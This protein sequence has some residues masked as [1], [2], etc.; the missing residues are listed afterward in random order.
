[1]S[2][3]SFTFEDLPAGPSGEFTL[4][5][6]ISAKHRVHVKH[7]LKYME[8]KREQYPHILTS[9]DIV[10]TG[11]SFKWGPEEDFDKNEY[12]VPNKS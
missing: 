2:R 9:V 11:V 12:E 7:L 8:K 3:P 1:M 10:Q 5:P 4:T 6:D